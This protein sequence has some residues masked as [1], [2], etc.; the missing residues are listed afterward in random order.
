MNTLKFA[1][2]G[3]A[4]S[5]AL[6][7]GP[8]FAITTST[9]SVWATTPITEGDK[10]IT[11]VDRDASVTIQSTPQNG[12]TLT[13][14]TAF[15]GNPNVTFFQNGNGDYQVNL[16]GVGGG[17]FPIAGANG[18]IFAIQYIVNIDTSTYPA[19]P[20]DNVFG[21]VRLSLNATSPFGKYSVTKRVQGLTPVSATGGVNVWTGDANYDIGVKFDGTLTTTDSTPATIFCGVCTRFLVTD[22]VTILNST[23]G[24]VLS[25]MTNTYQQV[26]VPAPAPLALIGAG[27]FGIAARRRQRKAA[28]A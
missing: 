19:G 16:T 10:T 8:A 15:A 12:A 4:L 2:L 5:L 25:Q 28:Q 7:G 22:Y 3:G 21:T 14:N 13:S 20:G 23:I 11:L 9:W 18:S 1:A 26:E 17:D 6:V 24:T 27:L